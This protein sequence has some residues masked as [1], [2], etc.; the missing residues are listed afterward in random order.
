MHFFTVSYDPDSDPASS[1]EN[2]STSSYIPEPDVAVVPNYI[3]NAINAD[4]VGEH[5]SNDGSGSAGS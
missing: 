2:N 1:T 3:T 5:I 4:I